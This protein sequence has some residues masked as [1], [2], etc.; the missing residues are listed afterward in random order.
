MLQERRTEEAAE[1]TLDYATQ[2]PN[3][4]NPNPGPHSWPERNSLAIPTLRNL[5]HSKT[6]DTSSSHRPVLPEQE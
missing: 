6:D 3:Q 2:R 5:A 4:P 1:E